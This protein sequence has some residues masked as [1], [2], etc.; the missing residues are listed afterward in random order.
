[1]VRFCLPRRLVLDENAF[2]EFTHTGGCTGNVEEVLVV[3]AVVTAFEDVP[4]FSQSEHL[5]LDPHK[6]PAWKHSQYLQKSSKE[7]AYWNGPGSS[8]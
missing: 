3:M 4:L 6:I 5:Q 2:I 7:R 8:N 1:M